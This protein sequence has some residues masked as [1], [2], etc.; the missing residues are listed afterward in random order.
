M[1][2]RFADCVIDPERHLLSRAGETVHVEPQV[3]D[4]LLEL[5]EKR[6]LM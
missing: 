2:Y 1:S 6:G 4:L 3:F 5:A